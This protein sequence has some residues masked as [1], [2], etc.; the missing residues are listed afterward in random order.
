[1]DFLFDLLLSFVVE[2]LPSLLEKRGRRSRAPEEQEE[3]T[4]K[5]KLLRR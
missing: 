3:A 4:A 2:L 1:M 5:E